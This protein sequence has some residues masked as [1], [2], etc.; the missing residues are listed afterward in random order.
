M[1]TILYPSYFSPIIHY[2]VLAHHKNIVFEV[3]D[4][5][6]KQTYRNR[7]YIYGANGKQLLNIPVKHNNTTRK[8]KDIRIEYAFDWQKQHIK[9]IQTAYR[10]SPYFEFYEEDMLALFKEKPKYLLDL[11]LRYQE[12]ILELLQLDIT[13]EKTIEYHKVYSNALDLRH[14]VNAKNEEY[15]SFS[16]Y[17]Q[18]FS[19]KYGFIENL[20]ILDLLFM[21]GPSALT[22]LEEQEIK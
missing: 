11:N 14:V 18:A 22:Y 4:H 7:C 16:E 17:F 3:E 15:F 13:F 8:T 6:Q 9:T 2:V 10:S 19:N 1:D 12:Q 5:F 20:S 21:E